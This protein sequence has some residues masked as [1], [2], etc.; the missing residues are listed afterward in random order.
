MY[1]IDLPGMGLSSRKKLDVNKPEEVINYFSTK[2]E[3]WRKNI[4]IEKMILVGH[5]IGGYFAGNYAI[6]H[7]D[8]ILNLHLISPIGCLTYS[9]E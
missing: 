3:Q 2:L 6:K 7:Q 8:R 1:S 9:E 4:K 5:S